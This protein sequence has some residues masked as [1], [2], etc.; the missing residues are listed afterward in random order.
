MLSMKEL[1]LSLSLSDTCICLI[2]LWNT[3]YDLCSVSFLIVVTKKYIAI[4]TLDM[5]VVVHM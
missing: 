3:H 5:K 1:S 2:V 4:L